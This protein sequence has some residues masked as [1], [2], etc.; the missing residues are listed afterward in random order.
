MERTNMIGLF[1]EDLPV[2]SSLQFSL[3]AEGMVAVEGDPDR[4]ARPAARI[5]I[6]D[7]NYRGDG[8]LLLGGLRD[9]GCDA[10]A[11]V[12]AT[13][14]TP[15]FRTRAKSLGADVIEKPLLGDELSNAIS[16]LLGHQK[17]A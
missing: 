13:N 5:L 16:T 15:P 7:Q 3:A 4:A 11:I 17:A 6:I 1:I 9:S 10:P 2:L 14:P 8:L 12:L